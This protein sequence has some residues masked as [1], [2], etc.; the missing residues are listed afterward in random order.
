MFTKYFFII[1]SLIIVVIL[2]IF[3]RS[4]Y[5]KEIESREIASN[6]IKL[7]SD[8][9]SKVNTILSAKLINGI[10]INP[11][12][13]FSFNDIVGP[14]TVSRGF[15]EGLSISQKNG[16]YVYV[17]DIGGGICRTSTNLHQAVQKAGMEVKE[18]HDHVIPVDYA[19]KGQDA[20][21]IYGKQDYKFKN[22]KSNPIKIVA[23]I[24]D[25]NLNVSIEERVQ[26]RLETHNIF[27][28][29]TL[30]Y[31]R[32]RIIAAYKARF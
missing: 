7:P 3:D 15:A 22:N 13:M 10:I 21:L 6:S 11:G 9:P 31:Y 30:E 26:V 27:K 28:I 16:E 23:F 17:R 2:L 32:D 1:G 12:E 14:R 20:A 24:K 8:Q 29:S 19:E 5:V 18:R 25:D 4:S